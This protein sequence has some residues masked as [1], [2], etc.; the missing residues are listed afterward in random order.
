MADVR[1]LDHVGVTVADV[2]A[3]TAFFL[4]LGLEVERYTTVEGPFIDSDGASARQGGAASGRVVGDQVADRVGG[5]R[6]A[7]RDHATH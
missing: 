1:Q 2:D 6:D 3:A 5:H 7:L 4:G